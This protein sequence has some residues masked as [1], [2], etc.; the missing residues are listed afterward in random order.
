MAAKQDPTEPIREQASRY[1]AVDQ[2]TACTQSS[3][4]TGK[5]AFLYIGMQGGRY[6]AMFKLQRSMLKARKLATV[7]PDRFDVGSTAWVTARFTAEQ[8]MP[9][10]LWQTWLDES[11]ALALGETESQPVT[12]RPAKSKTSKSK[13]SKQ[14]TSKKK[15]TTR[16][17][18]AAAKATKSK[19]AK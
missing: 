1:P 11:Y 16:K 15:K 9:K 12:R 17:R 4:K 19:R 5:R 10:R 13:T 2:G 8:P 18:P 3:F 14:K 6:K 7:E